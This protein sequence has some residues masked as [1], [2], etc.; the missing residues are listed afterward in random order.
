MGAM[1]TSRIFTI[2]VDGRPA[3]AFEASSWQEAKELSREDWF[4]A[5]LS[6]QSSM[7]MPLANKDSKLRARYAEPEEMAKFQRY[8]ASLDRQPDE[9]ELVYLV[10]IGDRR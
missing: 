6:L 1:S 9:L 3:V 5:D 4:R 2:E 7:G 8:R 10:E